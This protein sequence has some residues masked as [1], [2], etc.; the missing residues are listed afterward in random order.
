MKKLSSTRGQR[1][2][3]VIA[4]V[5]LLVVLAGL[6]AYLT[7]VSTTSQAAS[8]G[9]LN[10][11]RAYQAA[12]AGAEWAAYQI[13]QNPAGAFKTGCDGG[14]STNTLTLPSTLSAFSTKVDCTGASFTEGAATVRSYGIVSTACNEP[15]CPNTA[16]ASSVYV[17]RRITLSIAQ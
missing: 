10:A 1:G 8:A 14:T 13:L 2:F 5:F 4:A 9:D 12:R 11:A 6:A 3:L 17:E 7:S 16:T 15:A